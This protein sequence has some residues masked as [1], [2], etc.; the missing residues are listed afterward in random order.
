MASIASQPTEIPAAEDAAAEDAFTEAEAAED[1]STE[2]ESAAEEATE[3]EAA[4]AAE[5]APPASERDCSICWKTFATTSLHLPS[6]KCTHEPVACDSCLRHHIAEEVNGKGITREINCPLTTCGKK[7]EHHEIYR[8]CNHDEVGR[9]TF[10]GF[11]NLLVR[12]TVEDMDGFIWCTG[13]N[14]GSG[15]IH[16]GGNDTPI[17]RCTGCRAK[18]CFVHKSAYHDGLSCIEYDASLAEAEAESGSDAL[19]EAWKQRH[20]KPCPKCLLAIE[21]NSGCCHMTCAN[22]E[23]DCK[24]EF[25]WHCLAPWQEGMLGRR[26]AHHHLTTCCRYMS[27]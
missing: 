19:V 27:M 3:A 20:T 23:Q 14:C 6:S 13:E 16:V 8:I 10:E 5:E 18:T 17:V 4:P 2:A 15:Q 26:G 22:K 11:D 7:L 24:H 1:A 25:C 9:L 12:R 21:K